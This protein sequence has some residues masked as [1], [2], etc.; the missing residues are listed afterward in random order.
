[1][2]KKNHNSSNRKYLSKDNIVH[3]KRQ[4][5]VMAQQPEI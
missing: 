4:V 5:Q 1:M 2:F 3:D